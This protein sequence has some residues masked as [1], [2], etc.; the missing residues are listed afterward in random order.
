MTQVCAYICVC[1]H[2]L[3]DFTT[4]IIDQLIVPL[5]ILICLFSYGFREKHHLY[6]KRD[7]ST[8]LV[9]N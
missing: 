6:E 5:L 3:L 1:V 2:I 8:K 7:V 9:G 4:F